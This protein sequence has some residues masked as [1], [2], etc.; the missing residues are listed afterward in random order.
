[1]EAKCGIYE[2]IRNGEELT[3]EDKKNLKEIIKNV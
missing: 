2:K 3:Q 1:M